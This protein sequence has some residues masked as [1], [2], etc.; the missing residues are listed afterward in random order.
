MLQ[1]LGIVGCI[2]PFKFPAMV[3]LMTATMAVAVGNVVVLKPAE[4][5]PSAAL[6]LGELWAKAGLP[7][8]VWNIVNGEREAVEAMTAHPG[9]A[10]ISS[11]GSTLLDDVQPDIAFHQDEVCG[12]ARGS[13]RAADAAEAIRLVNEHELGNGGAT[14]THAGHA[15]RRFFE[16][17][18]VGMIGSNV[19]VPVPA[20]Y[21][22]FGGL[23]RSKFG[24]GHLFGPGA[25]R[26]YTK[27]KTMSA[28]WPEPQESADGARAAAPRLPV[29]PRAR[30]LA[31]AARGR[32]RAAGSRW[33][34]PPPGASWRA[35]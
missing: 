25:V 1:P 26:F 4:R 24:E 29:T 12:P 15:A 31:G 22:N 16:E 27:V 18:D 35:R 32:S 10:A 28:R 14:F 19:P 21:H 3:P 9:I 2:A 8:G 17:V 20:G 34:R 13:V 23:K 11:V 7:A 30:L 5:V 6:Q 33:C